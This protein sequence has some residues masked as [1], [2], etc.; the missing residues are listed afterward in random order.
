MT[1]TNLRTNQSV[2]VTANTTGSFTAQLGAQN[3]DGVR[4]VVT[5]AAGNASQPATLTVEPP[6]PP[7]PS[8]VAPAVDRTVATTVADSTAFLYTGADPIQTGVAPGTIEAKRAAVIR[9]TVL[10]KDNTPLSGVT[11]T[12]LNHPEFGQTLSRT[13]GRFDLAVNGGGLLTVTYAKTG[14]LPAQRQIE[15]PWQDYAV[16]PDVVLIQPDSQVTTI[17]L[18]SPAPMQ[19]AA[20]SP[21]T[22]SSGTRQAVVMIP[23]GTTAT[24]TLANGTTQPLTSLHVRLTEFTVSTNGPQTMPGTLP[25]NSGYTYALELSVDDALTVGARTVQFS[26]P[27][28]LYV[29]NFL[30]FPPGTTV[31]TGIYDR[32]QAA[33]VPSPN[34]KVIQVLSTTGGVAQ[35]DSNGDTIADDAATLTALGITAAEQQQLALT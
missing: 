28:P 3:G 14:Y 31:P 25:P 24:M 2:T 32:Q 7:D 26:T 17:D 12:I 21:V 6:L 27:L 10:K 11:I 35:I 30:N 22:D 4:L 5:D 18:T 33:W 15:A 34:G 19:V 16:L 9:G 1:L 13:D 23:Q 29:D 20:G 8:T